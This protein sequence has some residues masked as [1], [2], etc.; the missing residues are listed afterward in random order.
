MIMTNLLTRS[1]FHPVIEWFLRNRHIKIPRIQPASEWK[2]VLAVR[3]SPLP[4]CIQNYMLALGHSRWKYYLWVSLPIQAGIGTAV[5]LL[6]ESIL[7]G[8]ISYVFLAIFVFII[9]NIALQG[10][11]KKLTGDRIGPKQ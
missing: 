9:I 10:L 7:T 3:I 6:G 8:G 1:V 2:I 5:M 4:F 11:R